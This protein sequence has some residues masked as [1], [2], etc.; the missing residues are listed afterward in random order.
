[1]CD[2]FRNFQIVS[3]LPL[4]LLNRRAKLLRIT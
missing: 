3:P 2:H 1:M 4:D